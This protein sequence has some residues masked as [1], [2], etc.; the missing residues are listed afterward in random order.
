M[1]G[2]VAHRRHL[3]ERR[4][5]D[6]DFLAFRLGRAAVPIACPLELALSEDP[7]TEYKPDLYQQAQGAG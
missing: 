4:P 1:A 5:T 3:W 2:L 6:V 7:L